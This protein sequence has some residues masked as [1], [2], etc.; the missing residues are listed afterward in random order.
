MKRP[1]SPVSGKGLSGWIFTPQTTSVSPRKTLAE[2]FALGIALVSIVIS[3]T[4]SNARPST[5]V[6]FLV[7][8]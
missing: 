4:S 8:Q 1:L 7:R 3:R 2:P 6:F 5:L